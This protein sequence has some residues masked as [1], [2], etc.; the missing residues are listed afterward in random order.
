M[1][2]RRSFEVFR[3]CFALQWRRPLVWILVLLLALVAY[4]IV[5]GNL[6]ISTGDSGTAGKKAWFT[7]QFANAR[8][9]GALALLAYSFF[10]AVAAGMIVIQDDEDRVG[11]LL[12]ATALTTRE[13]AWGKWLAVAATFL[14]VLGIEMALHAL[15]AHVLAG[16]ESAEHVGPFAAVNYVRPALLFGAPAIVFMAGAS[17][18]LGTW[19]RRPIP[20]FFLPA[21]LLLFCVFFVWQ[22]E[23]T[24]LADRPGIENL[25]QWIDPSGLRWLEHVH[26]QVDRG[27]D[28]YN[29]QPIAV[30]PGFG[31]SRLALV[32][33]GLLCAHAAER[34]FAATLRGSSRRRATPAAAE[35]GA[36][37]GANAP[38]GPAAGVPAAGGRG[39][40]GAAAGAPG[41]WRGALEI[42]RVEARE[43]R[44]QPGLYLFVPL[45]LLETI[46]V[47][48]VRVG[49]FDT[50]LLATSGTLAAASFDVLSLLV[51]LLLLFYTVE[52]LERERARGLAPIHHAAAIRSGSLLL[53]KALA[54]SLVGVA[55][56]AAAFLG[57]VVVLLI[58][59]RAP[60]E[61]APFAIVWGLLLVPG[62]FAWTAFV[63]ALH[64]LARNRYATY[65]LALAVLV[66][67]G[68]AQFRGWISW[69]SSWNLWGV[70]R[71]SDLGPLEL[72][73]AAL[74]LNR[75]LWV[76]WGAAFTAF[77]VKLYPRRSLDPSTVLLRLR[78]AAL[79][80]GLWRFSPFL[81]APL[82]LSIALGR[83]VEG[84]RGGDAAEK[85][86]KDYWRK[87]VQTW[88]DARK[89]TL[90]AV[91]LDLRLEPGRSRFQARGS[92]VL[93]NLEGVALPQLAVTPGFHFRNREWTLDGEKF[94]PEDRAGLAVFTLKE[95]LVPG[96]ELELGF[97]HD[98]RFPDG[99]SRNGGGAGQF[100]LP[101]GV[102]LTSFGPEVVPM[103]GFLDGVGID[104]ENR[105]DAKEWPD[106]FHEGITRSAFG[107]D[108]ACTTRITVHV[109]EAYAANSVGVLESETVADGVRT[110]VW[111][112]DYPVEFFNVVCGRF[113]VRRG[114]GTAL[115][116]DSRHAWNVDEMMEALDGARRWFSE[117]FMP[118][119]WQELKVSE[120]AAH[121]TYAQGFPTNITF[122]EGIGFL[123]KSDPR[124]RVAFMV[125]A[126]EAAHQ[127]WGN[128]LVPGEGPGGN[129]LSEGMAH[130]STAL[131][132]EQVRGLRERIEFLK[133]IETQYA[134]QRQVDSERP[135][136]KVD[137]SRAGDTTVTYDKGGW[138]F[139]MLLQHMGRE[140][141]LAGL[142]EFL[143]RYH[144]ERDHPVL[145]DFVATMRESAADPAA[146]DDFTRQWFFEVV[147]P[148][149][150]LEEA[151]RRRLPESD[152]AEAAAEW[153]LTVRVENVGT[154]SMPVEL[155]AAR[156][157][158][159]AEDAAEDAAEAADY[160]DARATVTLAAGEAR[161]VT[162]RCAF[163]PERVLVDPDAHV[164]QLRREKATAKP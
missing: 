90:V 81:A 154:G 56:V 78:P 4:G 80:R 22:W 70:V 128:L 34:R 86:A 62:F 44:S 42:A 119:P 48:L 124:S 10:V 106:D 89:P 114:E 51:G 24:W 72:D 19:S 69:V 102:V 130:F 63:A 20:V 162:I 37:A 138:V 49:P 146:Y 16:A 23:P 92:Y 57:C 64:A 113:R 21:A 14:L 9:V 29:T 156:G 152:G 133:R 27:V 52:S 77:A 149:Y 91:E 73:R 107:N 7:S 59:G 139:W 53:G 135:L 45:I 43:L 140:R 13:Y 17:F 158:R 83:M 98:G 120:F 6:T 2:P 144:H 40:L 58:Q 50:P 105:S 32:L 125:T 95:P 160:R 96:G 109:P 15:C 118:Y 99:I 30:D 55:V 132:I 67:C 159:F 112:S 31:A 61:V 39:A 153:E 116:H 117:W 85:R 150:R 123:A 71:W 60:V 100:I 54:N 65:A 97:A 111:R 25:L 136:V 88:K 101:S 36:E 164:L 5:A 84:G 38:Q 82:A 11:E 103:I 127:W 137:G 26:L 41:F 3:R 142:R 18:L 110:A 74:V 163:E 108:A 94:E 76:A 8:W 143:R 134:R 75:L 141:C 47:G 145:Q 46:G 161:L 129:L 79:L 87:N 147:V 151:S 155:A 1:S 126:H 68:F 33:L 157:E 104:D 115:Y 28:H 35:A 93:R 131:L 121:A 148:E 66:G 122:S 12:H